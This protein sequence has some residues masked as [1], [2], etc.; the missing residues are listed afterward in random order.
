MTRKV[1]PEIKALIIS[2]IK[3]GKAT[4]EIESLLGDKYA[5]QQIAALRAWVTMGKYR[6]GFK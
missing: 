5:R 2:W 1:P 4:K 6:G 3:A